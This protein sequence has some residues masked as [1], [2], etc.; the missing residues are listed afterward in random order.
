MV[1]ISQLTD[2]RIKEAYAD[3]V[4]NKMLSD[5]HEKGL[6]S[7]IYIN[8][9]TASDITAMLH[10]DDSVIRKYG[11]IAASKVYEKYPEIIKESVN[12]EDLDVQDYAE[13]KVRARDEIAQLHNRWRNLKRKH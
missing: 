7:L 2:A 10:S 5:A 9:L 4:S 3:S 8:T 1:R 6:L 11:V 13:S 12:S